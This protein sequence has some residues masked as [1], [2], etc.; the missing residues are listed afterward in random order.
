MTQ[1]PTMC[2]LSLQG[3]DSRR[4]DD[5]YGSLNRG[6]V[7]D[8]RRAL[9]PRMA[10]VKY[11]SG[12]GSVV[13]SQG[14]NALRR[15]YGPTGALCSGS[16]PRDCA[17]SFSPGARNLEVAN[18]ERRGPKLWAKPSSAPPYPEALYIFI[19]SGSREALR[20]RK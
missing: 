1:T 3:T 14:A 11:L 18:R 10:A 17:Y 8:K 4:L 13:D 20:Q 15:R 19:A 16:K 9:R 7:E 12:T 5:Q 6:Q 2:H